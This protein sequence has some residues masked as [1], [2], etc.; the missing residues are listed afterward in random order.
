MTKKLSLC[1]IAGN[2]EKYIHRF[3]EQFGPLADE[4]I[5]VGAIGHLTPDGTIAACRAAGCRIGYYANA[6]QTEED[7]PQ[8][9]CWPHVDDY[10]AARN[11]ACDMAT[12]D[13]LMWADTDD[14]IT[15]QSIKAIRDLI[16][17]I[18]ATEI[19]AV[20]M[21]YIV[22]E[23]N[24]VNWRERIWRKGS[25]RWVYPVHE[26]I[27]FKP[28]VKMLRFDGAAIVHAAG[29]RDPKSDERNLRI[30]MSIS[31][32]KLTVSQRFHVFQSLI[33]LKRDG[34]AIQK[35][36]EF[37]QLSNTGKP[38]RYEAFFQLARLAAD[39]STKHA[40]LLQAL[41]TDP[42]RREA[43]G[44]LGLSSL[45]ADPTAADGWTLAMMGLPMPEEPP[46]NLRRF[47]YGQL[48]VSLRAMAL[49]AN[50][51]VK[52][53]DR[54]E[55]GHFFRHGAKISLLHATRGRPAQA[56]SQRKEWLRMADNA[57]A[58]EH[59]FGIDE[60]D[61]ESGPLTIAR[62]VIVPA[63]KGSVAAWNAC[64]KASNGNV[65]VQ[66]SDDFE[67]FHGWDTAIL[68]ALGNLKN[69]TVLAVSDGTRKD[70]LLCM[71]ILTRRRYVRQGYLFHPDFFSVYS[72]NW[73]S[74]C[75]FRDGCVI[76]ARDKITFEHKHPV[77]G[78]ASMDA[79][80]ARGNS[81]KA[82]EQGKAT[83]ERLMKS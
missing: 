10:A 46:W 73:F 19:D 67:P 3:L 74:H 43:Y 50:W 13:W 16:E 60:D 76:D 45:P 30:L 47:Y 33:A 40:M 72:D 38:E 53:A 27:Q 57:D 78:K 6:S 36:I 22:P 21:R 2:V 4:I 77:F 28:G 32:E 75:A 70:D 83:M 17:K 51:R 25:G 66:M 68:N 11:V 52:E 14:T 20:E 81:D 58:I 55:V 71:A 29:K 5:V 26:N 49:R 65:M 18:D 44:E 1:V 59:I 63:G 61:H 8:E 15:P 39:A 24:V 41:A 12:G 82:Y 9:W 31:E 35:A 34:E 23:D 79:T 7:M 56:W 54:I 42:T 80:Y 37:C 69:P 48:G 62:H 64:A